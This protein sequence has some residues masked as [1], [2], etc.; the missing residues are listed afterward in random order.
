MAD[1]YLAISQIASDT[2]MNDRVRACA[3]QENVEEYASWT[4]QNQYRWASSPSWGEKWAYALETHPPD[5]DPETPQYQPGADA[6]VITDADILAT[7][8]ALAP[9]G[10]EGES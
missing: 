9:A 2:Y 10:R 7:V 3:A 4:I 5:T 6:G 1:P 8:Q